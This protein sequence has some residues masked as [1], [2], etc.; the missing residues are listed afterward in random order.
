[1]KWV[2]ASLAGLRPRLLALVVIAVVP[3]FGLTVYGAL[4]HERAAAADVQ[5]HLLRDLRAIA[6]EHDTTLDRARHLLTAVAQLPVVRRRQADACS[7]VMTRLLGALP[8]YANL[9][10]AAADGRVFCSAVPLPG[11]VNIADR[12]YFRQ[13]LETHEPAVSGYHV[14]RISREPTITLA[15]PVGGEAGRPRGV[16]FAA[17]GLGWLRHAVRSLPSG[18]SLTVLDRHGVVLARLPED[19]GYIGRP[20]PPTAVLRQVLEQE[21]GV[22]EGPDLDGRPRLLAF[23]SIGGTLGAERLHLVAGV[24]QSVVFASGRG[25]LRRQLLGLGVIALAVVAIGWLMGEVFVRR[26]V[27][28]LVAAARRFGAGDL[29]VRVGP[30]YGGGEL[31]AV[32]RAF[33]EATEKLERLTRQTSLVLSS[34]E[35]GICGIDRDGTITFANA[36]A[37]RLSGWEVHE[38]IGRSMH[39]TFHHTRPDGTP[40]PRE[41]CPGHEAVRRGGTR[42]I[43]G[44]V[45]WRKD[46]TPFDVEYV[47]A[48]IREGGQIVGAVVAFQDVTDRR[49]IEQRLQQQRD[50]LLRSEKLAE[51]GRLAAG[52]A[53]ELRNPLAVIDARVQLLKQR[54]AGLP[55]LP[56]RLESDLASL[57][58]AAERMRRITEGLAAYARPARREPVPLDPVALLRA[59]ADLVGHHAR[60]SRVQVAMEAP[61]SLPA[62]LGDRS[63]LMQ[64]LVNLATNAIEAMAPEGG[65]LV[66]RA[67]AIPAGDRRVAEG[68]GPEGTV[69]IEVADTGPGIPPEAVERI[70]EPFYTT[71]TEG[72]GLGL[73]IVGS[74]VEQQPGATIAVESAPGAGTTFR[75]VMPCGPPRHG[76]TAVTTGRTEKPS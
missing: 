6:V 73:A 63:Q 34:V 49:E 25:A 38:L 3:A 14:G 26:Q 67:R 9:G 20:A 56:E 50:A 64:I 19:D 13:A 54:T 8:D 12:P 15:V 60:K 74:L 55:G 42:R 39:A 28:I 43:V 62:V 35:E 37:A 17:L 44:E 57:E 72:T 2:A 16:V 47:T 23:V 48:P 11:G 69:V 61:E 68:R 53:H 21:Q 33:D 1:V 36:A 4:E 32:G 29:T 41:E 27:K 58:E 31:G 7:A 5:Q 24:P 46:G 59:L 70:W 66:L 65:R 22:T 18:H 30:R 76:R 75:L 45:F 40:Y 71:K 52:V 51:L 10:A